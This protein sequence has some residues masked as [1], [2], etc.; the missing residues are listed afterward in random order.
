MKAI[1]TTAAAVLI[2]ATIIALTAS[3]AQQLGTARVDLQRR[4]LSIPGREAIQVRVDLAPGTV[5]G[6]HSHSGEELI[7]VLQGTFEYEVD[8]RRM[9]LTAG[10]VLFIPAGAVYAARNVGAETASELATYIVEKGRPLA[11]L[12]P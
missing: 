1:P 4:D 6:R 7:Y 9:T 10:D 5:A 2:A 8:G 12:A 3:Q 11:T